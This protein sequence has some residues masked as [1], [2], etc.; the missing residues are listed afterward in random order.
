MQINVY[1]FSLQLTGNISPSWV[2]CSSVTSSPKCL[3]FLHWR[4]TA[5]TNGAKITNTACIWKTRQC[6]CHI[7]ILE[8]IHFSI[9]YMSTY[10]TMIELR[11]NIFVLFVSFF[12][13]SIYWLKRLSIYH[14]HAT[15]KTLHTSNIH[16]HSWTNE[17]LEMKL[18]QHAKLIT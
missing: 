17:K 16:T 9:E 1:I 11:E 4:S 6:W 10:K 8:I 13:W 2:Q 3:E 15:P 5:W 14:F 18:N 12:F 7:C